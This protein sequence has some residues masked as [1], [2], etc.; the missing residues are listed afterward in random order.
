MQFEDIIP[1]LFDND[2]LIHIVPVHAVH[3]VSMLRAN[4]KVKLEYVEQG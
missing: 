4:A 2:K 1:I 3:G